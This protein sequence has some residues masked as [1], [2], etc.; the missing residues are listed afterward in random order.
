[1]ES[2]LRNSA[3]AGMGILQRPCDL[4]KSWK[5]GQRSLACL[6]VKC[7]SGW[8]EGSTNCWAKAAKGLFTSV[9]A[10]VDSLEGSTQSEGMD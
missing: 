1:M 3:S 9:D 4:R 7:A 2:A 6:M 5:R 8:S 10:L